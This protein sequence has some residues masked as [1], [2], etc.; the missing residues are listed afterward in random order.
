M[1][2]SSDLKRKLHYCKRLFSCREA[3]PYTKI[4]ENKNNGDFAQLQARNYYLSPTYSTLQFVKS[5]CFKH[6][7]TMSVWDQYIGHIVN[8]QTDSLGDIEHV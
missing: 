7:N 5:V 3:T 2:S 6:F 8:N 1:T 4:Q